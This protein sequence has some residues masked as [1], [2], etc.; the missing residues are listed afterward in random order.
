VCPANRCDL[1]AFLTPAKRGQGPLRS[2]CRP[3]QA[4]Q[5]CDDLSLSVAGTAGD[6]GPG[7]GPLEAEF[8]SRPSI[9]SRRRIVDGALPKIGQIARGG[10]EIAVVMQH[11]EV[12]MCRG[13]A[14]Q[15][16]HG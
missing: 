3:S 6:G 7:P 16:V 10:G 2:K 1:P 4:H 9:C 5:G 8:T 12:M 11:H 15:E 13:G 14:D